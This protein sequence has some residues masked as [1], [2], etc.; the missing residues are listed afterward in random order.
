MED[1]LKNEGIIIIENYI[2]SDICANIIIN[3]EKHKEKFEY[4]NT[5]YT[6]V[7]TT[8]NLDIKC[9]SE[10]IIRTTLNDLNSIKTYCKTD[11]IHDIMDV[12]Y[13]KKQ[14]YKDDSNK[15]FKYTSEKV[16][17]SSNALGTKQSENVEYN[18]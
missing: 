8:S 9:E 17:C 16:E 6:D 15:C 12:S 18:E 13:I 14:S 5:N 1:I 2:N 11:E 10:K 4:C 3:M 7:G